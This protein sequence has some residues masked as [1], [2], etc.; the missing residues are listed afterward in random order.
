MQ[1]Q[2]VEATGPDL[3]TACLQGEVPEQS[4]RITDRTLFSLK[5]WVV[6]LVGTNATFLERVDSLFSTLRMRE[7]GIGDTVDWSPAMRLES[8]NPIP[9]GYFATMVGR[10][11][12]TARLSDK[13]LHGLRGAVLSLVDVG[14][15]S[16][17]RVNE[18]FARLAESEIEQQEQRL[19]ELRES[20][21][22]LLES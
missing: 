14:V 8:V 11:D 17:Q 20:Q 13:T 21:R 4:A 22:K 5:V 6:R 9:G 12:Q 7:A 15:D 2:F 16:A 18:V 1:L 19:A 3:Y 10:P